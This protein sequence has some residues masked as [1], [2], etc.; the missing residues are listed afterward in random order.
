MWNAQG[1][2]L[3]NGMANN[4]NMREHFTEIKCTSLTSQDSC[5]DDKACRW[6]V[7][8]VSKYP[9]AKNY[10]KSLPYGVLSCGE[11]TQLKWGGCAQ[12]KTCKWNDASQTCVIKKYKCRLSGT[13]YIYYIENFL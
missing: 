5:N 7:T 8:V 12:D 9:W 4:A 6:K 10:N 11:R 3:C 1:N 13:Y 2:L